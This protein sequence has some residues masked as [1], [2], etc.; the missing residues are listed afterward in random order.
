MNKYFVLLFIIFVIIYAYALI[1]PENR[2]S[3]RTNM[4]CRSDRYN[5]HRSRMSLPD[6]IYQRHDNDDPLHLIQQSVYDDYYDR[7]YELLKRGLY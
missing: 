4:S 7:Q 6:Y 5:S 1:E 2:G 3:C